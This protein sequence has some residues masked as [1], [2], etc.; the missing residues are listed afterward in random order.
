MN[1]KPSDE[2]D[3]ALSASFP[4]SD[5]P[6]MT[7]PMAAIAGG[8][9][10]FAID[11]AEEAKR[12]KPDSLPIYR[13]IDM[14]HAVAPFDGSGND[15]GGRWTSPGTPAIY[16]SFSPS[17]ALLEFIAH[18]E[19]NA[20]TRDLLMA[21]ALLPKDAIESPRSLPVDW[22]ERPYR[23][24]VRR[25]GDEWLESAS[26]VALRVPSAL[27]PTEF[28]VILNPRHPH[29]ATIAA[30]HMLPLNLDWRLRF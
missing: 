17:T 19:E 30:E 6:A 4:A 8:D 13:V 3:D 27:C 5:P 1:R 24:N 22:N 9:P 10:G 15:K 12:A 20:A 28:N 2:L 25:I 23:P 21:I 14:A 16:A 18:R 7:A 11:G 29:F 26:K